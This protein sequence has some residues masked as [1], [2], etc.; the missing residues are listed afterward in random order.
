M[1]SILVFAGALSAAA[2]T[3]LA[4]TTTTSSTTTAPAEGREIAPSVAG[5]SALRR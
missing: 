2:L 1:R 4:C 3:T 5:G